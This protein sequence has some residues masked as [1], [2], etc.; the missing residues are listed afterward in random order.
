MNG[1]KTKRMQTVMSAQSVIQ[2]A[3]AVADI[4]LAPAAQQYIATDSLTSVMD[5]APYTMDLDKNLHLLINGMTTTDMVVLG[6]KI[7]R[8]NYYEI[9]YC[10]K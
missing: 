10:I 1:A 4:S 8:R 2:K 6:H 5:A 9:L 7:M 3:F